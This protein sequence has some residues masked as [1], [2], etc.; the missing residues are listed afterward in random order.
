MMRKSLV[1]TSLLFSSL[2]QADMLDA[3]KHYELKDY[4][5][6]SAE[7]SALLPL[8]NELAAFNLAVMH[9]KGEG[10]AT[11]PVKALAYFQLA[12]RLGDSRAAGLISSLSAQLTAEEQQQATAH[13]QTL[14]G[15]VQIRDLPQDE[16]VLLDMPEVISRKAPD[17]P[18]E[19]A[20]SGSF[21]YTVM[22]YL[23]DEQGNVTTVEVLGSFP[24][25][26]FNK[27]SVRAI[28]S[29]KYA[30]TGQKHEGKVML[31]YSLGP[32][33]EYQV[34]K[35]MQEHKLMEYAV[36]GSPQHQFLL[37]TLLD[38]LASNSSYF[39]QKDSALALDPHAELP[40]QFFKRH[41]GF[42]A[43]IAGFYGSAKVK[44]DEKGKV[45]EVLY[46]D[47]MS[48]PQAAAVLIGKEL[49]EDASNGYFRLWADPGKRATIQP[50]AAISEL[51]TSA[52]WWTM[53]AKNG[54]LNAQRQLA[55]LSETWEN[56]LLQANDPQVQAWNGVRQILKGNKAAGQ[57]L[58]DKAIAQNYETAAE[59]KAAL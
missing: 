56:Y 9:Y 59:L 48:K 1:A 50:V 10:T 25:K 45:S 51:H 57:L 19:A 12:D 3:L 30:A 17:Y 22:K 24:D 35:F 2:L 47:K 44:T 32:L 14:L 53:A 26:T 7:F 55:M 21:G 11:D 58:L 54:N 4:P 36:A 49:D 20:H 28:K 46:S 18:K 33:K 13:F 23:I 42:R 16:A 37:G 29:W 27:A 5:K 43:D 6:A 38:M 34:K 52:Y 31:H 8:G 15:N 40:E 39:I 41:S